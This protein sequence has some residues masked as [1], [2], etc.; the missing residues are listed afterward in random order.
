LRPKQPC[1]TQPTLWCIPTGGGPK[2]SKKPKDEGG[3]E[4][5]FMKVLMDPQNRA[6]VAAILAGLVV[7]AVYLLGSDGNQREI[8]WQEFRSKYLEE[9]KVERIEVANKSSARVYVPSFS[10][11]SR[12][13]QGHTCVG[14]CRTS[15][16]AFP[17][18]VPKAVH[19]LT[20]TSWFDV[21][22]CR[23]ATAW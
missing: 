23:V 3:G 4:Q 13:G 11:V 12:S 2:G 10:V 18:F 21:L 9:G 8:T 7:G 15:V 22:T 14:P 16:V 1:S 19:P 20:V 17:F 6:S 5:D